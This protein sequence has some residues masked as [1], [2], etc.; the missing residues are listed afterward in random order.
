MPR[1]KQRR[2]AAAQD[3]RGILAP[4]RIFILLDDV[5]WNRSSVKNSPE[6]TARQCAANRSAG[7]SS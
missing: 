2:D 4:A 1:Q 3:N 5:N 6:E 7:V